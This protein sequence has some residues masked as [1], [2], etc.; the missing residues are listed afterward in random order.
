V[1]AADYERHGV[2]LLRSVL[3]NPWYAHAKRRGRYFLSELAGELYRAAAE[4][5]EAPAPRAQPRPH[6]QKARPRRRS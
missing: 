4:S 6:R 3:M 2:F 1:D 5:L